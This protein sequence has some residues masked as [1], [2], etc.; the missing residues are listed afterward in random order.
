MMPVVG[1][2]RPWTDPRA[3]AS[4]RLVMTTG[5]NRPESSWRMALDGEWSMQWV[6]QPDQVTGDM[7]I[8]DTDALPWS[9]IRVPGNWNLQGPW[10]V[11]QYLNITMPFAG[12]PPRLPEQI[13]TAVYRRRVELPDVVDSQRILLTVGGALSWHAVFVDGNFIGSGSDSRLE[14]TY[15]LT[16][17]VG[18][19]LGGS[20]ARSFELA[21]VVIK[22]SA[23]SYLEDQDCWW[24]AGLHRSVVIEA[25]PRVHL[26][27]LHLTGDYDPATGRGAI[28]AVVVVDGIDELGP[29]WQV[30]ATLSDPLGHESGSQDHEQYT[31]QVPHRHDVPY[32]FEGYRVAL[33]WEIPGCH[34]WSAERPNLYRVE[35]ELLDPDG[36]TIDRVTTRTG[37]RRVEIR[38][39]QL[40]VNGQPIW[41]DGVNR[42]DIHP[43]RGSALTIDDMIDDL[44]QMRAHNI[45]AVRTAHYPN[46]PEFYDLCDEIG[47]YVI[48]EANIEGHAYNHLLCS[49]DA[50]RAAFLERGVRMVQRDRNHPCIIMWSL[51]NETGSGTNQQMLAGAIRGLDPSRP[52]HYEGPF[53]MRPVEEWASIGRDVTDVVCPM[54]ASVEQITEY[55]RSGRGDR[56][57]ILCEYSHAMGNSNGDLYRYG[58]AFAREPGLQGGFI[59]EWKDHG[60]RRCTPSGEVRLAVGGDF[61]DEPNDG[62]FVADGLMSADLE[63]HPALVEVAWLYRPVTVALS[64]DEQ[65]MM[66]TSRRSFTDLS[67]LRAVWELL[68]D[69]ETVGRGVLETPSIPPLSV[70]EVPLPDEVHELLSGGIEQGE[71]FLNLVWEQRLATG[72]ASVGHRC[73]WDQLEI[74]G[75]AAGVTNDA[76]VAQSTGTT[77]LGTTELGTTELGTAKLGTAKPAT[78]KPATAKPAISSPGD[79]PLAGELLEPI[80]LWLWRAPVDNDGFKLMPELSERIGVGGKTMIKWQQLGLPDVD[81]EQLAT[82]DHQVIIVNSDTVEHHHR[83]ETTHEDLA[84][85]GVRFALPSRFSSLR[86]YGRGPHENYPDRCGSS[87]VG[88]WEQPPDVI[89]YL[90]PQEFGL[91]TGIRWFEFVDPESAE[92]WRLE[93]IGPTTLMVSATRHRDEDLFA[94]RHRDDLIAEDALWVH[95]DGAHRG[96]GTASCGPDTSPKARLFPGSYSFAYRIERRRSAHWEH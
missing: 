28:D 73:A 32:V 48:D 37:C 3:T 36:R 39:R 10:D 54:Y 2:L 12:P 62:N 94:T 21:I 53:S 60:L 91:R 65:T 77:E 67:D 9:S 29:G 59:W 76:G 88:I 26:A 74:R 75:L 51:G 61:G 80:R 44:H 30:R 71:I 41:I 49:D 78:A 11:P 66:I 86:W 84:R 83:V 38:D 79:D 81:H 92:R 23:P 69:G 50:Y 95:V 72:W 90:V 58:E 40:L 19:T 85:I 55:A 7:L 22:Y 45:T 87:M 46:R 5:L 31:R 15:D 43:D 27:D 1:Q 68:A 17:C 13:P 33:G 96:V 56:P 93:T 70:V 57:L 34:P 16:D 20:G 63:P 14:S 42:H 52:L 4:S 24:L 47:M 18:T 6:A 35:V 89:P 82:H 25:V 8:G 64:D